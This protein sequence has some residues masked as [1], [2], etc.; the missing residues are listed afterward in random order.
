M[1]IEFDPIKR[2]ATVEHPGLDM[3]WAGEI[4]TA[5]LTIVDD[6]KDYVEPRFISIAVLTAAWRSAFGPRGARRIVSLRKA[7]DR[8]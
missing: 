4:F 1:A 7:S 2:Q 5:T 3:A 6:R 8:E